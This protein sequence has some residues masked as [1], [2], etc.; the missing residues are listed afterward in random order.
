MKKEDWVWM[1]HAGHFICG[2]RCQ[3]HLTT[4][5]G[6]YVVSTLGELPA[7]RVDERGRMVTDQG[8]E[9]INGG[10]DYETMVFRAEPSGFECCPWVMSSPCEVDA[11]CYA[12][13]GEAT[14]GHMEMCEKWSKEGGQA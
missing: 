12:H 14:R 8:W 4:Y 9:H 11:A 5:V 7:M 3:F 13:A 1:P 10:C 2:Q 6:G